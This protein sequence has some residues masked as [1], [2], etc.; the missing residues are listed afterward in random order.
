VDKIFLKGREQD[1]RKAMQPAAYDELVDLFS[2]TVVAERILN[3]HPSPAM[4]ARIEELLEKNRQG[5]L[6]SEDQAELDEV[7][8]LEHF[9]RLIKARVRQK[10]AG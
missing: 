7:E 2:D 4:Q 1:E 8:R 9:M 10:L 3:F 5:N 6:S